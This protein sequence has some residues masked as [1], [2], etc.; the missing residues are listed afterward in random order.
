MVM[1]MDMEAEV[2]MEVRAVAG[3]GVEVTGE[4]VQVV[5]TEEEE[6]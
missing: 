6:G 5:V 2:V 4:V 1:D 3:V